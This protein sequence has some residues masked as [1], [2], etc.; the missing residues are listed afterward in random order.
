[1]KLF[2]VLVLAAALTACSDGSPPAAQLPTS[3]SRAVPP[4]QIPPVQNPLDAAKFPADACTLITTQDATGLGMP[5][6]E[7]DDMGGRIG[8]EW[9]KD[10]GSP[11]EVLRVQVLKNYG[12]AKIA[13]ECKI[14]CDTWSVTEVA[15]YPAIH[16]NGQLESKYGM[17]R[18]YVGLSDSS[19]VLVTDGDIE[20]MQKAATQDTASGPKCDRADQAAGLAV[21]KLRENR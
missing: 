15:G 19:S 20:A 13:A 2:A 1:V 10:N 11:L 4:M 3:T 6:S 7:K 14:S 9:R 12:L 16:A 21:Q 18:L 8:C 17:C 5:V